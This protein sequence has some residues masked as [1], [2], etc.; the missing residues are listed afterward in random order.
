MSRHCRGR[1]IL[2]Q[3]TTR[4]DGAPVG[5][6]AQE[7]RDDIILGI[8]MCYNSRRKHSYLGYVSPNAD[9]KFARVP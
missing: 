6:H 5:R 3:L 9:E 7:A 4:V 2:W 1:A 8:E